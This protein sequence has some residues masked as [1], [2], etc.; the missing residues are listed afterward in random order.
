MSKYIK[1]LLIILI[2]SFTLTSCDDFESGEF[3]SAEMIVSESDN[4]SIRYQTNDEELKFIVEDLNNTSMNFDTTGSSR[5]FVT[6]YLDFN[7]NNEGDAN[8][9]KLY[10]TRSDSDIACLSYFLSPS[11]ST[12][13]NEELGYTITKSFK[14]TDA[15]SEAHV[16]HE[17][18]IR[19]EFLPTTNEAG[20]KFYMGGI[21]SGL[22]IP[23]LT[24]KLF[25]NTIVVSWD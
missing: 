13:C 18:I 10:S 16:V 20:V 8:I 7:N 12:S 4:H 5:D 24:T 14:S 11:S 17:L 22:Y 6:L 3:M 23:S 1:H 25:A 21:D 19:K 2:G 15:N 9:D